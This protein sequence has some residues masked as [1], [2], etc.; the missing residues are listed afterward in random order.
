MLPDSKGSNNIFHVKTLRSTFENDT[1]RC[2]VSR[3]AQAEQ[4]VTVAVPVGT[5]VQVLH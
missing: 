4:Y 3:A 2:S 5:V 1:A